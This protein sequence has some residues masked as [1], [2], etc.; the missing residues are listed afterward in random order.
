MNQEL[1]DIV[2]QEVDAIG[3]ELFELRSGGSRGRPVLDV[4]I[5][6]KDGQAVT[7][8]DCARVSR[9]L[10][11]R[12]DGSPLIAEKYVLE[13]SSPGVERP[14]RNARDW[15]RSVGRTVAVTSEDLGGSRDLVI[16]GIAGEEGQEMLNLENVKGE[17]FH[18]PLAGVRKARLVFHWNR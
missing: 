18:I 3:L 14:L 6:R 13:V 1:E 16:Q 7:V 4:R 2:R 10:E 12:F 8:A 11:A 5:E 9:A 17:A 15:A